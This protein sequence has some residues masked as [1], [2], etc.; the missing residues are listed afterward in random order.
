MYEKPMSNRMWP[1]RMSLPLSEEE[2]DMVIDLKAVLQKQDRTLKAFV[3]NSMMEQ[4]KR[5][6]L[7]P[8]AEQGKRK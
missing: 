7:L 8:L 5:E 2:R 1:S 6:Q 4:I 3:I